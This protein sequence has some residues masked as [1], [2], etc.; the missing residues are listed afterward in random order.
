MSE[1]QVLLVSIEWESPDK[2]RAIIPSKMFL[3]PSTISD[4]KYEFDIVIYTKED[5]QY[6][7]FAIKSKYIPF[8]KP[9][10]SGWKQATPLYQIQ[11]DLWIIKEEWRIGQREIGFHYCPSINTVGKLEI[12]LRDEFQNL[13]FITL[14]IN[15]NIEDF[16]FIQLKNDFEGELWNLITTNKSHVSSDKIEIRYCNKIFRYPE[17]KS[18]VEFLKSF[19]HITKHPKRE[20]ASTKEMSKTEKVIPIPETYRKLSKGGNS[21]HLP[22]RAFLE[23]YD[24]YENRFVCFMLHSIHSIVSK[25]L[26]YTSLQIE[27]LSKEIEVL[28]NKI[29]LLQVQDPRVTPESIK[30]QILFQE[31]R[32][33]RLQRE[34]SEKSNQLI[35]NPEIKFKYLKVKIKFF[36]NN[37]VNS[38][39]CMTKEVPFCVFKFPDYLMRHLAPSTEFNLEAAYS[40]IG[41]V[42][43]NA[44]HPYPKFEITDVRKIESTD[45]QFE[46]N[47]LIR[48]KQNLLTLEN[49]NWSQLSILT[50]QEKNKL[51]SERNNQVQTL[52][53]KIKVLSEQIES[54]SNFNLEQAK[55]SPLINKRLN[56]EYFK[57]INWKQFQGFKPSMSF[58]Q[59][60][61]YRNAFRFYKEIL[62][63]EGIDIAIFDLYEN[64]TKY[65]LREMPQIYELWCLVTQIKVLEDSFHFKHFKNDLKNLLK[66]ID[67]KKQTIF[68]Y[69]KINFDNIL[70]G[71]KVT[72]HYQKKL[73]DSKRPDFILEISSNN[74]YINLVMDSKFKN[75]NY[76]KSIVYETLSMYKKYHNGHN[77]VFILHPCKDGTFQDRNIKFTN[78]GGERI[79]YADSEVIETRFPFHEYGYI[80]LKP[81]FTDNLKKLIAMSFE[82]LLEPSKNA[83]KGN[84]IDPKP[85]ND[86]FCL[87]CG[88]TD[89]T[90]AESSRGTNRHFYNCTC[91]KINCGHKISIDY[92]WNCQ[93]KLFKHG[94][95]WDYHL[96]STWSIFDIRCPSCGM[97]L[98]D[99]PQTNE[100]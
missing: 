58:I 55:I 36:Y 82:Y 29:N 38:F 88:G 16:D 61:N 33:N 54:L 12:G 27:R 57:N 91:N 66:N 3:E 100:N 81:N 15:S 75:Y 95:Y 30:Q 40:L 13:H 80:E 86:I 34:W 41:T 48:Q 94:S 62:K 92:C 10:G 45:L 19:D 87:N 24:V 65:S 7:Q 5:D 64:V 63:S 28:R 93:T 52:L 26:K 17:N 42:Q 44:G 20:L 31:H 14:D 73:V 43:T 78:H 23:N 49:S 71:R 37:D 60:I 97:T 4:N 67:P 69:S 96:E 22:S 84:V 21:S 56:T 39:W 59:N 18:I 72:L 2:V 35:F 51:V 11:E 53:K 70:A 89:I 77:Y 47:I 46:T 25:N 85:E 6:F 90:I 74:R 76:K 99:R 9:S 8:L 50:V 83:R 1:F 68:E 79:F 98:A 32:V